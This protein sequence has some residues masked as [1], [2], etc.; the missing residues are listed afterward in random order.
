MRFSEHYAKYRRELP[1]RARLTL[2]M[3]ERVVNES[4]ESEIQKNGRI[5]YWGYVVEEV[6]YLKVVVESNGEEIVRAHFDRGFKK[7]V[8]RRDRR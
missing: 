1:D 7:R 8:E 4:I 3:C 5:A 6:K 2:L